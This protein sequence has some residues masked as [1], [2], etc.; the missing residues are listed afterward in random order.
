MPIARAPM[1]YFSHPAICR[2]QTQRFSKMQGTGNDFILFDAQD[3]ADPDWLAHEAP[4]LCYR[5]FGIGS[6][7][8]LVVGPSSSADR[9]WNRHLLVCQSHE[10]CFSSSSCYHKILLG[11]T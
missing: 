2:A 1:I 7:G 11:A 8:I 3:G 9:L 6:D 4:R 10:V 5:R